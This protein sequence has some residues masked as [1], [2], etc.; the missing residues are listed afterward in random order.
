[1]PT[2]LNCDL[3]ERCFELDRGRTCSEAGCSG[4][5]SNWRQKHAR[6]GQRCIAHGR[7]ILC[8]QTGCTKVVQSKGKCYSHC[9]VKQ[10]P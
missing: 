7:G 1:M 8:L 5:N 6:Q 4:G 9:G 2:K 10:C 3:E